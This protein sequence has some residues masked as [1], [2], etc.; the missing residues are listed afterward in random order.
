[1]TV[2]RLSLAAA[3]IA[4]AT[5]AYAY[6]DEAVK[7]A[8]TLVQLTRGRY[9][10]GEVTAADVAQAQIFLLRMKLEAGQIA[11]ADYCGS[12]LPNAQSIVTGYENEMRM[13]QRTLE[14]LIDAKT[15]MYELKAFCQK[16]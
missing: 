3:A 12:A 1:M 8:E 15:K 7:D 5:A 11:R 14:D 13:G 4:F 10:A 9:A 16:S 2:F 6:S